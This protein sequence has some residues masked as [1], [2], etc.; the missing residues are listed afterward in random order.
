[1]GGN[2]NNYYKINGIFIE[3]WKFD[4]FN[5]KAILSHL[6]SKLLHLNMDDGGSSVKFGGEF[7]FSWVCSQ[8][9]VKIY[10]SISVILFPSLQRAHFSKANSHFYLMVML[11]KQNIMFLSST[12]ERISRHSGAPKS[13][14]IW[15]TCTRSI[16]STKSSGLELPNR[17]TVKAP[18]T[19]NPEDL[20][21]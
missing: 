18:P 5:E 16:D 3:N 4:G 9:Y 20:L 14:P 2:G 15:S 13:G 19:S 7:P 1:M 10:S 8:A 21:E 11:G 6:V 12:V 17:E